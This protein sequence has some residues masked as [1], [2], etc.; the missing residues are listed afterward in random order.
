MLEEEDDELSDDEFLSSDDGEVDHISDYA[1]SD[2]SVK[3]DS[4]E[5][6]LTTSTNYFLSR[7][8]SV[9]GSS[10]PVGLS[11]GR[12]AAHN[13]VH[14]TPGPS[15]FANRQCGS[16]IDSFILFVRQPLMETV[17]KWTNAEGELVYN[18]E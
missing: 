16:V 7:N 3:S 2:S 12:A 17:C 11:A 15:R 18:R 8:K 6:Q 13:I 14:A 5:V 10:S 4:E 9:C 1:C